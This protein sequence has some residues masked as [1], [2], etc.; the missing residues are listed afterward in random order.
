M[1]H[2]W[3]PFWTIEHNKHLTLSSCAQQ[4]YF[5]SHDSWNVRFLACFDRDMFQSKYAKRVRPW[6]FSM[7]RR[8]RHWGR[9]MYLLP[10]RRHTRETSFSTW[11]PM[12]GLD[13]KYTQFVSD[14]GR[15]EGWGTRK[16]L[17]WRLVKA[18]MPADAPSQGRM[19]WYGTKWM[20]R[21]WKMVYWNLWQG[22]T[23]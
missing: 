7:L 19:K 13:Y 3:V 1:F 21:V 16:P 18:R 15:V 10:L 23:G 17:Y 12:P 8:W 20:R 14:T 2:L 5:S 22:K 4:K 9:W 6:S 11:L